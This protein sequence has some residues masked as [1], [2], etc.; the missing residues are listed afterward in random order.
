MSQVHTLFEILKVSQ[1]LR[2]G[3]KRSQNQ[4]S[5]HHIRLFMKIDEHDPMYDEL[6]TLNM[7][8]VVAT[9]NCLAQY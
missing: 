8:F 2:S 1:S 9:S 3:K 5:F 4:S 7:I 6:T